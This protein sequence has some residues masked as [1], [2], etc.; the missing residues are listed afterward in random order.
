MQR[1][2]YRTRLRP[3]RRQEY[4]EAHRTVS[5][6]LMRRYREAGISVLRCLYTRG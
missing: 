5:S 1:K 4:I 6:D 2:V 3:E